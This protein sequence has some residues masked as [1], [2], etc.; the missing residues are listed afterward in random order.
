L[1]R[2]FRRFIRY[3]FLNFSGRNCRAIFGTGQEAVY[4]HRNKD[5]HSGNGR[6][7]CTIGCSS[8]R[9]TGSGDFRGYRT[10]TGAAQTADS[11][12]ATNRIMRI[13]V[14]GGTFNPVHIGHLYLASEVK[15]R[16]SYD[17][18][19]FIPASIPVHKETDHWPPR[20]TGCTCSNG[21]CRERSL[22][23]T[24]AK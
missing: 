18:V 22:P 3:N 11:V 19:L 14:L 1:Y 17:L 12:P 24:I 16:F 7:I 8:P 5:G 23:W 2:S 15:W 9:C 10:G 20:I 21:R 6:T 13:A 4:H